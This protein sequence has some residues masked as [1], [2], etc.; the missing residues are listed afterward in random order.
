[1][2]ATSTNRRLQRVAGH[3]VNG[4]SLIELLVV[5]AVTTILMALL[6]PA[7]QSARGGARRA[8]CANNLT[9]LSRGCLGHEVTHGHYPT[10]G[11]GWRWVL[12]SDRGFG[13]DQPGGWIGNVLPYI[14]EES[15]H[16]SVSD[17]QPDELTE[18]QLSQA[19]AL[20]Q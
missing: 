7:I 1:M 5:V 19:A 16:A 2:D 17:G 8:Q 10:G 12:D 13:V 3:S 6:L 9:Q 18:H 11:W 4:V 14:E 20:L 15:L